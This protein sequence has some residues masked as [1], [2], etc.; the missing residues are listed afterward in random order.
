MTE[1]KRISE[2]TYIYYY[3]IDKE[4]LAYWL[5]YHKYREMENVV[6]CSCCLACNN[7]KEHAYELMVTYR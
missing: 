1:R 7:D 5:F 3:S 4:N 2:K 6:S